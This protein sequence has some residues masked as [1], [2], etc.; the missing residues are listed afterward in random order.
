MICL[1]FTQNGGAALFSGIGAYLL[2]RYFFNDKRLFIL[3]SGFFFGLAFYTK[4]PALLDYMAAVLFLGFFSFVS[5]RSVK[6]LVVNI[7]L[8][9]AGF[10]FIS[11]IV[12]GYFYIHNAL[13]DFLFYFWDYNMQYYA[14]NVSLFQI[15]KHVA[16]EM[17]VADG[18]FKRNFLLLIFFYTAILLTAFRVLFR[19]KEFDK[20]MLID[21]YLIVWFLF[22]YFGISFSGRFFGHYYI[23]ALFPLCLISGKVT[24]FLFNA[25][26]F[27]AANTKESI[28]S[29]YVLKIFLVLVIC[30][31]VMS[32]LGRETLARLKSFYLSE[33]RDRFGELELLQIEIADYIKRNSSKGET[34]LV[35][36]F[37]SEIY[38]LSDRMPASRFA[39]SNYL[40][41][42]IPWTN[43]A[44]EVDT[45]DMI[46]P[47][48]WKIFMDELKTNQP[49]FII[50][51]SVG[52]HWGYGK[53]PIAK[54]KEFSSYIDLRYKLERRFSYFNGKPSFKLYKRID[55]HLG[56]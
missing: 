29:K 33:E 41:G 23:M 47:G 11:A 9:A 15:I 12:V 55:N 52:N 53:Y 37:V 39:Y 50:D 18:F 16:I 4:Q 3:L 49:K 46:V 48:S 21:L 13:K 28:L 25:I 7:G 35:W 1:L 22:S 54:Y 30:V 51:T 2:L 42:L 44:P 43:I 24:V 36:G 5:K 56:G 10:L 27:N 8:M 32:S 20:K 6:Q 31:S 40:T 17:V 45:K 19:Y 26:K 34:I 38:P 14:S